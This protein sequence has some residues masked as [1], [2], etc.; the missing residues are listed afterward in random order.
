MGK[1]LGTKMSSYN[2]IKQIKQTIK[3]PKVENTIHTMVLVPQV[4]S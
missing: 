3:C 1:D 2:I 4:W